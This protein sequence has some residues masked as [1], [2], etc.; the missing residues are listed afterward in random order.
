MS[1]FNFT[2]SIGMRTN[3][4]YL[5]GIGCNENIHNNGEIDYVGDNYFVLIDRVL[6]QPILVNESSYWVIEENDFNA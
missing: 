3:D 1:D 6:N 5:H 4:C 2:P